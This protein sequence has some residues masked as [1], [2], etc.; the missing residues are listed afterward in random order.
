MSHIYAHL[1]TCMNVWM[2]Y[3]DTV[4]LVDLVYE[5]DLTV[6]I[7][8]DL[9]GCMWSWCRG[10]RNLKISRGIEESDIPYIL[11]PLCK[12]I[13]EPRRLRT[14][15][16][17]P[18]M[19]GFPVTPP[20][21]WF[22]VSLR[23]PRAVSVCFLYLCSALLWI[24]PVYDCVW[25]VTVRLIRCLSHIVVVFCYGMAWCQQLICWGQQQLFPLTSG[26]YVF[27]KK[28]GWSIPLHINTI[29]LPGKHTNSL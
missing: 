28:G 19:L 25:H 11:S 18:M 9:H 21:L 13:M 1:V 15:L 14:L 8:Y 20:E 22:W 6:G 2:L 17:L 24:V 10:S 23:S 12:V 7:L 26:P 29:L 3:A 27:K 4:V 16:P 5:C